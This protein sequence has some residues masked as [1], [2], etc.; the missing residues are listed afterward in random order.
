MN[1]KALIYISLFG[2]IYTDED[3]TS[4]YDAIIV[5]DRIDLQ[6]LMAMVDC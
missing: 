5:L 6:C 2:N 1:G 3:L 4:S